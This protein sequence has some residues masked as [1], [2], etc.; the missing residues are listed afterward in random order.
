MRLAARGDPNLVAQALANDAQVRIPGDPVPFDAPEPGIHH[1]NDLHRRLQS[2]KPGWKPSRLIVRGVNWLGLISAH[3]ALF[4]STAAALAGLLAAGLLLALTAVVVV[5]VSVF[6]VAP[7]TGA[8][9][10]DE[11]TFPVTVP[12][13]EVTGAGGF[14]V[15]SPQPATVLIHKQTASIPLRTALARRSIS[16]IS[17]S[18]CRFKLI[19]PKLVLHQANVGHYISPLRNTLAARNSKFDAVSTR[20][21]L[22]LRYSEMFGFGDLA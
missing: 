20:I 7:L 16:F 21:V 13:V 22:W 9:L 3:P 1:A 11:R 8:L 19:H 12:A 15:E 17:H 18:L 6:T 4:R 2:S 5:P 10:A 14:V